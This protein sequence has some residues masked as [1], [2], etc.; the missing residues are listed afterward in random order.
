MTPVQRVMSSYK[1]GA[2]LNGQD[3]HKS[4]MTKFSESKLNDKSA[5][6]DKRGSFAKI[7]KEC[8][9]K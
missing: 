6:D 2:E 8:M 1:I 4:S 9:K 5:S 3:R 7:L